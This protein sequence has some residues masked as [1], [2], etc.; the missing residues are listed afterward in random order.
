M[1][2]N[3]NIIFKIQKITIFVIPLL[4]L[5]CF[6][7]LSENISISKEEITAI[8]EK[9]YRNECGSNPKNLIIWHKGKENAE[10]G[11]GHFIWYPKKHTEQFYEWFPKYLHF[12][13]NKGIAY[14]SCELLT[15]FGQFRCN[16][17]DCSCITESFLTERIY[18]SELLLYAL[19]GN[20]TSSILSLNY[21]YVHLV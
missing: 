1:T 7:S 12:L 9:I 16:N 18:C 2:T 14:P 8:G 4:I 6:S 10:W 13:K 20:C 3:R 5:P 21:L 15:F 19:S 17:V 11:I